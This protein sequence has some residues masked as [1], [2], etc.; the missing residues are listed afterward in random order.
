MRRLYSVDMRNETNTGMIVMVSVMC[1][2][3][4]LIAIICQT[5]VM[6]PVLPTNSNH[7]LLL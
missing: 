4:P 7:F 6:F 5:V 3:A 2:I 1:R